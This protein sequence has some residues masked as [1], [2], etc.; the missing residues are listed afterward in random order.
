MVTAVTDYSVNYLEVVNDGVSLFIKKAYVISQINADDANV[1]D[2]MWHWYENAPGKRLFLLEFARFT[3]VTYASA[4]LL[5]TSI[6]AMLTT[7]V[8]LSGAETLT[9]KRISPR[10][11][12][13]ADATS[14]TPTGDLADINTQVNTQAVGTLTANAPDGSPVDGQRLRLFLK[15]TNVQTMSWHAAYTASAT[16]TLPTT[17]TG[18]SKTDVFEFEYRLL[19]TKWNLTEAN[20]GYT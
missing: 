9:N 15:C 14:F 11:V 19:N 8:T 16:V 2:F 10:V 5:N 17:T 12:S 20:Y 7:G 1:V 4:A 13:M 3:P 6:N 18:T